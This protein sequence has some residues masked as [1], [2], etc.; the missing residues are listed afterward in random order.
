MVDGYL[1]YFIVGG[2]QIVDV[3]VLVGV[4]FDGI[5]IWIGGLVVIV[6][7]DVVV[8]GDCQF[9]LGGQFIVWVDFG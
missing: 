2:D 3:V 1:G 7:Y 9:V 5:D 8:L 6:D 4:F